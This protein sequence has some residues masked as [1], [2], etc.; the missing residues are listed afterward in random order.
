MSIKPLKMPSLPAV[1][2]PGLQTY[3]AGLHPIVE[4][5]LAQSAAPNAPTNLTVTPI[6]GGNVV[7]FTRSNAASHVLFIS[8]TSDRAAASQVN[9]GTSN[10]YTDNVG[11]GGQTRYYWVQGLSQS[12]VPSAVSPPQ[13]GVTLAPGASATV[14]P[15]PVQS[16]VKVFDTTINRDRPAIADTD[17]EVAG[18]PI[19]TR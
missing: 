10:V 3:L 17:P 9:L 18:Q 2:D 1:S 16:A 15:I 7:Q 8:P 5:L 14:T 19:P 12:G 11:A 13:R 6:G 4:R